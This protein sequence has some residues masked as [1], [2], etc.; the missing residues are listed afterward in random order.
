[1][2]TVLAGWDNFFIAEVGASAA[3]TGLIFVAVSLNLE[4][5]VKYRWLTQRAAQTIVVLLEALLL[6]SVALVPH[7][8]PVLLGGSMLVASA[9][10]WLICVLLGATGGAIAA[11]YRDHIRM[12]FALLQVA[13]LPSVVGSVLLAMGNLAGLYWIAG[14]IVFALI[15]GVFNAWVFL[16]EIIR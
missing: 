11:E 3:L 5:I 12:N 10:S 15:F 16:V 14:A 13:L 9:G 7:A 8:T 6:S 1:V 2:D 4:R